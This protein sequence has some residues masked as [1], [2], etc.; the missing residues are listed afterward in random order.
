MRSR[1]PSVTSHDIVH[2]LPEMH[3][4]F[5]ALIGASHATY[6]RYKA[7]SHSN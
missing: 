3:S 6:L 1:G 7:V 4:G 5:L 2:E